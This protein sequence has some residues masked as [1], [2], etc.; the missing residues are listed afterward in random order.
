MFR[1]T[2]RQR[3]QHP[4]SWM[5]CETIETIPSPFEQQ[6]ILKTPLATVLTKEIFFDR[7]Q[8]E[9][10]HRF[11]F[12]LSSQIQILKGESLDDVKARR[13]LLQT[14]IVCGINAVTRMLEEAVCDRAPV[15]LLVILTTDVYPSHIMAHLPVL[16]KQVQAPVLLLPGAQSSTE[17]GKLLGIKSVAALAFAP[18]HVVVGT[19]HDESQ[20]HAAVDSL[21]DFVR[22][23]IESK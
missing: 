23:K 6:F 5:D 14:R 11:R 17:L 21:A 1:P 9:I 13:S 20:L 2:K 19:T 22:G 7:L 16:A 10:V 12:T 15:P 3:L 4:T 18:H 8:K